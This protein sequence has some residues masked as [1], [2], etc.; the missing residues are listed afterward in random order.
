MPNYSDRFE[1][2]VERR[3]APVPS[4]VKKSMIEAIYDERDVYRASATNEIYNQI[5]QEGKA[6]RYAIGAMEPVDENYT[7]ITYEEGKRIENQLEK[8][9]A[10]CGIE[11]EYRY[12]GSVPCDLHI[13]AHSDIDMLAITRRFWSL[14][15]PLEPSYPYQG[16]PV[17]DLR[18]IR[19]ET[20]DCLD[21]AF[22]QAVV[23]KS[24]PKSISIVGGS[25][26][27]KVDIVPANWLDTNLYSQTRLERD[28]AIQILHDETG[29]RIKNFP[30][31]HIDR[32]H[33]RDIAVFGG[34]RKV[35]RLMKSLKYDSDNHVTLS[36]YDIAGIA[37]AIPDSSLIAPRELQL[38][39][40]YRLK[41]FLDQL[42]EDEPLR[43]SLIVPDGTRRVF[44]DGHA[45]LDRLKAMQDEVDDLVKAVAMDLNRSFDKLAEARI[46]FKSR[47][48]IAPLH[49]NPL[50]TRNTF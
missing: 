36:S 19:R 8:A 18:E 35:A 5:E 7:R 20:A 24:G 38:Q 2:L 26:R 6:T 16:K 50:T 25:L 4:P 41:Q 13:K 3:T 27:R 10:K 11:C 23:D 15:P 37:Y 21:G 29:E 28:R 17:E 47:P 9:F 48:P 31:L 49:F 43:N 45:N 42:A 14:E 12:Q 40:L 32:V 46:S 1:R 22:P 30:F 33:Q 34:M 39:L 44:C